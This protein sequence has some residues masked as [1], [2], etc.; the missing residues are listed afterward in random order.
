MQKPGG[1]FEGGERS[2]GGSEPLTQGGSG[3]PT[4]PPPNA[5][6]DR[7]VFILDSSLSETFN[8]AACRPQG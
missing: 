4:V 7:R 1:V 8:K 6:T 5:H 3:G 2:S